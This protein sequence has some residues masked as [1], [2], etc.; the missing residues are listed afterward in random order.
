MIPNIVREVA[1][2][3][4]GVVN[5]RQLVRARVSLDVIERLVS[6]R[7]LELL[8]RGVYA[9]PGPGNERRAIM[10]AVLAAG[11]PCFASHGA[12]AFIHKLGELP[13]RVEITVPHGRRPEVRG[14]TLHRVSRLPTADVT[15][16]FGIPVTTPP[17]TILDLA[18]SDDVTRFELAA[19]L[20]HGIIRGLVTC[21]EVRAALARRACFKG[22][23]TIIRLLD[24]RPDGRARVESPLE[25]EVQEILT[26]EG[27]RFEPQYEVFVDGRFVG[28]I[29]I[30]F[31]EAHLGLEYDSYLWHA[32][33]T[34]WERDHKRT[35]ELTANGWR[36]L[37]VT[38]EDMREGKEA[39]VERLRRALA[40]RERTP[41]T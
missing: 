20:D 35:S 7:E 36:I 13:P 40:W 41:A 37:P 15:V 11:Y 18:G 23:A 25:A 31:P 9:L 28:R 8:H 32:S 1:L 14:A 34:S 24:Q 12:A 3:Q 17:R 4:H 26:S 10:A 21:D 27:L 29:D 30:A 33:R 39:F 22:R 16:A 19:T 5:R 38:L 2:K 6:N